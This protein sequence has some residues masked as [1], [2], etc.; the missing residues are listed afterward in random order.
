VPI[1]ELF[2]GSG[3]LLVEHHPRVEYRADQSCPKNQKSGDAA[4][5]RRTPDA[6]PFRALVLRCLCRLC[7]GGSSTRRDVTEPHLVDHRS[8]DRQCLPAAVVLGF[9]VV[10]AALSLSGPGRVRG[11]Y[12]SFVVTAA[13][14]TCACAV[15][16]AIDGIL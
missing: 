2:F 15:L 9:L 14:A 7:A 16:G 12:L 10:L 11:W 3:G 8:A 6:Q 5:Y 4:V 1:A 13:T